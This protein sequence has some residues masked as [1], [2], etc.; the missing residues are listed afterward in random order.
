[1][2]NISRYST[3]IW[4]CL[5]LLLTACNEDEEIILSKNLFFPVEKIDSLDLKQLQGFWNK[6][7]V[8]SVKRN[9]EIMIFNKL[10]AYDG[11]I[12][13]GQENRT[14]LLTVFKNADTA[15]DA[16]EYYLSSTHKN[17]YTKTDSTY[18]HSN[19]EGASVIL[20]FYNTLIELI[21]TKGNKNQFSPDET[22]KILKETAN[23][24]A[25][26]IEQN[27]IEISTF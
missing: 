25:T 2:K 15:N 9:A 14:L 10:I 4:F 5:L 7:S 27:S 22:V 12:K 20:K 1:M 21:E 11:G 16:L 19:S 26:K 18:I 3:I 23:S 8:F 13:L 17:F 24:V 6:D